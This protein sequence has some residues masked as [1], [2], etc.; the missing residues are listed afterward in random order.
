MYLYAYT[1]PKLSSVEL[2]VSLFTLND[3]V[4]KLYYDLLVP[5]QVIEFLDTDSHACSTTLGHLNR[6]VDLL[7]LL[8][9]QNY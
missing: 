7:N 9:V 5:R 4:E 2:N 3:A 8:K 1:G 6:A